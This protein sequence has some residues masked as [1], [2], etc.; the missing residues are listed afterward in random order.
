MRNLYVPPGID[1]AAQRKA[2]T[3]GEHVILHIHSFGEECANKTHEF[4]ENG[5]LNNGESTTGEVS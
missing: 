3:K 2:A 4:Y 1:L 5:K